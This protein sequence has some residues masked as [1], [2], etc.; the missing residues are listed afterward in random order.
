[1]LKRIKNQS[2]GDTI[3]DIVVALFLL[4]AVVVCVYPFLYVIS[5]SISSGEAVNKGACYP[6]TR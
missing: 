5:V 6:I 3:F 2:V 1:M 4:L